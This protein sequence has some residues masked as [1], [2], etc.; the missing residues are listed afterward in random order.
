MLFDVFIHQVQAASAS[1]ASN[2]ER[3]AP[4]SPSSILTP[5]AHEPS[6]GSGAYLAARGEG[7]LPPIPLVLDVGDKWAISSAPARLRD[8]GVVRLAA[9]VNNAGVFEK[10]WS[11]AAF[12]ANKARGGQPKKKSLRLRTMLNVH[13][14]VVRRL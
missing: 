1:K 8:A 5:G 14:S 13:R 10:G 9:L 6:D 7:L 3:G 2:A 12:A 11:E 4:S